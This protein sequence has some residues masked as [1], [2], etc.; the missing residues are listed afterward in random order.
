MTFKKSILESEWNYSNGIFYQFLIKIFPSAYLK[1]HLTTCEFQFFNNVLAGRKRI[2]EFGS[3]GST[4]KLLKLDRVVYSVESNPAFH[5]MMNK[6]LKIK[7]Y[8]KI[9]KLIYRYINIGRTDTW[10]R[11]MGEEKKMLW[12]NYVSEIWNEIHNTNDKLDLIYIDGRFRVSCALFTLMKQ[13][14]CCQKGYI[15]LIHD[16]WVRPEYHVLLEFYNIE[17]SMENLVALSPKREIDM[18]H[19]ALLIEKYYNEWL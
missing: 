6:I 15:V 5:G 12:K 19:I 18:S 17:N 11:P 10:G 4:L 14:D 7:L 16:F 2:L 1:P 9:G 8:N 13:E 3:G